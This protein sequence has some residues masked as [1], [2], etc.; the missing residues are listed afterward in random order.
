[1]PASDTQHEPSGACRPK[2]RKKVT[3]QQKVCAVDL[4]TDAAKDGPEIKNHSPI[5]RGAL[6]RPRDS[7]CS[8]DQSAIV[9]TSKA[10]VLRTGNRTAHGKTANVITQ[11]ARDIMA[12]LSRARPINGKARDALISEQTKRRAGNGRQGSCSVPAVR[13][14]EPLLQSIPD[15]SGALGWNNRHRGASPQ[16]GMLF[17]QERPLADADKHIG[18]VG[19][20]ESRSNQ[21]IFSRNIRL[22]AGCKQRTIDLS[23]IKHRN[24]GIRPC[25]DSNHHS[26]LIGRLR[27]GRSKPRKQLEYTLPI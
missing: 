16:P 4:P 25:R 8:D 24:N 17:W 23:E 19:S 26:I 9:H 3:D 7:L 5:T 22:C 20:P 12:H 27:L 6:H 1:M 14:Q 18:R 13:R 10:M 15:D 11:K 2:P 21:Q